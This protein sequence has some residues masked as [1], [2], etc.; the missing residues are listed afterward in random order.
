MIIPRKPK[1]LVAAIRCAPGKCATDAQYARMIARSISDAGL[2]D[3]TIDAGNTF[4]TTPQG[5]QFD[6]ALVPHGN[7]HLKHQANRM[8][9]VDA[10]CKNVWCIMSTPLLEYIIFDRDGYSG[11]NSLAR[12]PGMLD[13]DGVIEKNAENTFDHLQ[14]VY[15]SKNRSKY[16]QPA[17]APSVAVRSASAPFILALGQVSG[18]TACVFTHFP[19]STSDTSVGYLKTWLTALPILDTFGVPVIYKPHPREASCHNA[20]LNEFLAG[21]T[22]LN[23][24]V[25]G[26]ISLHDLLRECAGV[27]T[28][29]SGAG[30]E[31]LMHLKPVVTM[32]AV[33]YSGATL[34]CKSAADIE[35]ALDYINRPVDEVWLKRYLHAYLARTYPTHGRYTFAKLAGHLL[36]LPAGAGVKP[37]YF[38]GRHNWD[39]TRIEH[40]AK[41]VSE[42]LAQ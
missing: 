37:I 26:E 3:V 27:I 6:L 4:G 39:N 21:P 35:A 24:S 32:G 36:D 34:N 38:L 16:N 31:A 41:P 17:P 2:F 10:R 14:R 40:G 1:I 20:L 7:R 42:L 5:E 23:A 12:S 11:G 13:V 29:N 30:F 9:F 28:I 15:I 18:D 19:A 8:A 22:F 25:A 33:D